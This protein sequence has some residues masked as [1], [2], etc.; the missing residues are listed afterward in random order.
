MA[1]VEYPHNS[2]VQDSDRNIGETC[3][4]AR[5]A[6]RYCALCRPVNPQGCRLALPGLTAAGAKVDTLV[7]SCRLVNPCF[8][9]ISC[10]CGCLW[11]FYVILQLAV[12]WWVDW[13]V[14]WLGRPGRRVAGPGCSLAKLLRAGAVRGRSLTLNTTVAA[15]PSIPHLAPDPQS[16]NPA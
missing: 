11:F 2:T 13:L 9:C 4:I 5:S 14:G 6:L 16:L 7:P 15:P 10:W 1:R 8:G 12:A 3:T